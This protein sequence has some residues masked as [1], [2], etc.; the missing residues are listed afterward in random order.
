VIITKKFFLTSVLFCLCTAGAVA[1]E[2]DPKRAYSTQRVEGEAP[3]IDG[4]LDDEAWNA[5][6]WAGDFIG[7]RPDYKAVPSQQTQFKILY[8]EK[9]LYIGIRAFD[10]EP[11]KIVRRM[12]RRDGFDGDMVEVNIDS[13]NDKRTAFSFT[14]SVSG[15]KGD[16]YISNNGNNWDATW[17]PIWDLKTSIDDQGWIAEMRI[18]LSQLRFTNNYNLTWGIQVQRM[19]FRKDE[20]STW[21]PVDPNAPGWVHLFGEL[22]GLQGIKPQKQLEIQPYV[23]GSAQKYPKDEGNP[24]RETGSELGSNF[25]VDAKI[26]LTSDITLD[27][28]VNPDFGQ[29]DADPSAVNLSAFQLF[30]REQR[31]FFLEGNNILTF[32]TSGG[33]NNLFYSRRIGSRPQGRPTDE[34]IAYVDRPNNTPIIGAAKLTGKNAKGFSWGFQNAV[35]AEVN[36]FVTDTLGVERREKIEPITN[37]MVARMQ[38][39]LNE[40]QTVLGAIF[41][42]VNRF[43]NTGNGLDLLHDNAQSAGIDWD[44][45][46]LDRKYG[47][48]VK[49]GYSQVNGTQGAIYQT[50]T[51]SERFFQRPD[52]TYREVDSTRTSLTGTFGAVTFGKRSGNFVY[53]IGSNF[54]SPELEINDIG[55]LV[56]TDNWNHWLNLRYR[57]NKPTTLFRTQNYSIYHEQNF[58]FGGNRTAINANFNGGVQFHNY[59]WFES[60]FSRRGQALSNAELRGGPA[61]MMPGGH[62]YWFWISSNN[63]KKVRVSFDNWHYW[64][65]ENHARSSGMNM[66]VIVRPIDAL[67][68]SLT[69][70]VSWRDFGLQYL[71]NDSER[72]GIYILGRIMQQ[73]YSMTM[74]VNYNLTPNLTFEFWGQP[75]ISAGTYSD[76][77]R[78]TDSQASDF[79]DRYLPLSDDW[80]SYANGQF[81]V[82]E[83][84][85]QL[86]D[87]SFSDPDFNVVEFRSN[88][89]MRWEY[90]PGSTLF[91]VW[92]NNGSYFDQS[93]RND[94][95]NLSSQ[96]SNLKGTN[97]FLIKYTYRFVL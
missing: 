6:E 64:G 27:L 51:S 66:N 84:G 74:R 58:D 7:H 43:D 3:I 40:G 60:G 73:T 55:F 45:N 77:K 1:Q 30:F 14:A 15:V 12:S 54:R 17:D 85:D 24:Y 16:E 53:T 32:G 47:F 91:A 88:F 71:G 37:F 4:L 57:V 5:V 65:D 82:D 28:N 87:Y 11:D 97:T 52:N 25:G 83:D 8:D 48:T 90:I 50:Q 42:S 13:Y 2:A 31:P 49:F 69:P 10:T 80:M 89:V 20:R 61:L 59:W 33:Q 78:V 68:I 41:T 36:A 19:I 62:E 44:Q 46:I 96:L 22:N 72:D 67:N 39:D 21:Q 76:F 29:V 86:T 9:Y 56:F 23:V 63:Q 81:S 95:R 34:D 92:S 94:F 18:P 38:Q 70:S 26:G 79:F 93:E 35:T 75:F